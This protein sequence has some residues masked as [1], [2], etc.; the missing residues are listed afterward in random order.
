NGDCSEFGHLSVSPAALLG[1]H[2]RRQPTGCCFLGS[3]LLGDGGT[4]FA[5]CLRGCSRRNLNFLRNQEVLDA[6]EDWMDL[7]NKPDGLGCGDWLH[8]AGAGDD[9]ARGSFGGSPG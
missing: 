7:G 8:C 6:A 9:P 4:S 5:Q 3:F 1:T 2:T